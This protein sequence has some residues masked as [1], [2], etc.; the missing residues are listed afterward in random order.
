MNHLPIQPNSIIIIIFSKKKIK[1]K[2]EKIIILLYI[3]Q[4]YTSNWLTS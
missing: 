3:I 4:E 2:R 1:I